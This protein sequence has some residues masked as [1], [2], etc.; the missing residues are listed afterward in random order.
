MPLRTLDAVPTDTPASRATSLI[1]GLRFTF[2]S[3]HRRVRGAG[4]HSPD[5]PYGNVS[6]ST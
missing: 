1:V 4:D 5:S 2:P 6:I 3:S